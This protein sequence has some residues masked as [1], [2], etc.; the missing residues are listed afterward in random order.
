MSHDCRRN[1]NRRRDFAPRFSPV[2]AEVLL[3]FFF[4]F[5]SSY[6]YFAVYFCSESSRQHLCQVVN[7]CL[8]FSCP[9]AQG[10]EISMLR[11][12]WNRIVFEQKERIA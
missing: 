3:S 6:L 10:T 1:Q 11:F 9:S 4:P 8:S 5:P 7:Y 12:E 2:V